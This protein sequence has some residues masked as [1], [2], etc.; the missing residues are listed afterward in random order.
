MKF[1][2]DFFFG[3]ATAAYQVEGAIQEDGKGLTNW[4][5]FV[6]IPGKTFEGTNR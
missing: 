5:E 3:A 6:T 1:S 4:D 2:N